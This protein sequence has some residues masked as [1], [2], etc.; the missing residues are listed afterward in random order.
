MPGKPARLQRIESELHRTLADLIS[1]EVKD[2]RVGAVTLTFV[3]IAPDMSTA[4]VGFVPF[5]SIHPP[6]EVAA[7]LSRAAGFLRGEAGRRLGLRHAPRLEF[8]FDESIDRADR[9]THAID[10][11]VRHDRATHR[12]DSAS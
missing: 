12:D 2:P 9:L 8:R 4:R 11:A 5:H 6:D 3:E 1:R 10:E 7:G